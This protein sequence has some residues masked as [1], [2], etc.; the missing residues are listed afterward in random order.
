MNRDDSNAVRRLS[1]DDA[2]DLATRLTRDWLA[3]QDLRQWA[4][5]VSRA[6]PCTIDPKAVGKTPSRWIVVVDWSRDDDADA[7]F[8][9]GSYVIADLVT[10][11]VDWG[12]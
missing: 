7:V 10:G 5:T 6:T 8:D 11:S 9:G 1:R 4:P 12:G 2:A 3:T